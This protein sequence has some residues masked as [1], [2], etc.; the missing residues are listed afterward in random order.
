MRATV[1]R[2]RAALLLLCLLLPSAC[3]DPPGLKPIRRA[4]KADSGPPARAASCLD[5]VPGVRLSHLV[6]GGTL[7]RDAPTPGARLL[8]DCE[9]RVEAEPG[10]FS[11]GLIFKAACGDDGAA[12]QRQYAPAGASEEE[13]IVVRHPHVGLAAVAR[14][15]QHAG[16]PH[17]RLVFESLART[18]CVVLVDLSGDLH[19]AAQVAR[20]IEGALGAQEG[21]GR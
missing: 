13:G 8:F 6:G 19:K 1:V 3:S 18:G 16:R 14:Q 15:R 9:W 5:W 17:T 4:K 20:S 10:T 21:R 2:V 7:S 11:A 12:L